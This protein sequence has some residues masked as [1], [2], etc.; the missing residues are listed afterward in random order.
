MSYKI[1]YFILS[2]KV[3]LKAVLRYRAVRSG[4]CG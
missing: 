2:N 1:N 3:G 4:R